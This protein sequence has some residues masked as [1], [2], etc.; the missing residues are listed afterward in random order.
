LSEPRKGVGKIVRWWLEN[1]LVG[2]K[3]TLVGNGGREFSNVHPS[4]KVVGAV[5]GEKLSSLYSE[6]SGLIFGSS[7]DNAPGVV[8]EA[9]S[10]GLDVYCLEPDM[11]KWLQEDGAPVQSIENV[12]TSSKVKVSPAEIWRY[13]ADRSLESVTAEYVNLYGKLSDSRII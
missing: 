11:R 2:A 12:F 3:L 4:I 5:S 1:R 10:F 7:V 13:L 6:A 8:A 9:L